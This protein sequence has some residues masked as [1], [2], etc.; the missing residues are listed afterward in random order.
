MKITVGKNEFKNAMEKIFKFAAK[1]SLVYI[2]ENIFLTASG[3]ELCLSTTNLTQYA[4]TKINADITADMSFGFSD[5]KSLL[6]AMKFFTDDY[7]TLEYTEGLKDENKKVLIPGKVTVLCGSKK[8]TQNTLEAD[9]CPEFPVLDDLLNNDM[10]YNNKKLKER[11]IAVK[12]AVSKDEG[13]RTLLGIYFKDSDMAA[14]NG[15]ILALNKD[16][17]FT[18][19]IPFIVPPAAISHV[20]DIMGE[21]ILIR[22]DK[23]YIQFIDGADDGTIIIS[24]LYEGDF[25]NYDKILQDRG[26]RE[27]EVNTKEYLNGLKYLKTFT[28][29]KEKFYVSW[30]ENKLGLKNSRG[31]YESEIAVNNGNMDMEICFNGD[32]MREAFSQFKE[33]V[34]IYAGSEN[35]P[36]ILTS[37][38][39]HSNTAIVLPLRI[40]NKLF[41]KAA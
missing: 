41:Q 12:Y 11:F 35:S 24:R 2:L 32:Y 9:F 31:Y 16:D 1:N 20:N 23:K 6:K 3:N 8:A 33:K 36:M 40:K 5:T 28:A 37:E 17:K 30:F 14:C 34:K 10:V 15:D 19:N 38:T 25:I 21:I 13:K 22:T 39:D 26:E 4:K 7:V 29:A 27:I 18:V